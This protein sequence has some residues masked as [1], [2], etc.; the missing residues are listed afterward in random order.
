MTPRRVAGKTSPRARMRVARKRLKEAADAMDNNNYD[1][2]CN[3]CYYAVFEAAHALLAAK[4]IEQP[5]THKGINHQFNTEIVNKGLFD[6]ETAKHFSTIETSR[7]LA[8]YTETN[9][10]KNRAEDSLSLAG[11]FLSVTSASFRRIRRAREREAS[12]SL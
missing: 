7:N 12:L 3:R 9:V 8:D 5:A 2:V 1:A 10:G 6:K 4:G 11:E